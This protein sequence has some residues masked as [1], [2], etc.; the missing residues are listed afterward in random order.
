MKLTHQVHAKTLKA[1]CENCHLL[2]K[3]CICNLITPVAT[4]N[5]V[6]LVITKGEFAKMTN[7]GRL[8]HLLLQNS[9]IKVFGLPEKPLIKED[10]LQNGYRNLLLYP[11]SQNR[12]ENFLQIEEPINLIVP[13]GNWGQA[14]KMVQKIAQL[15][16]VT[17]VSLPL[18][19]ISEYMLRT[20]PDPHRIC[21]IEAIYRS[22][23]ILENNP[24][25]VQLLKVFRIMRDRLVAMRAKPLSLR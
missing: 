13:D 9:Q 19:P 1:I 15:T 18:G 16:P 24:E 3:I 25:L 4:R 8:A 14:K 7:T 2:Q 5:R 12:F 22:L 6:S 11:G 23:C 10:F 20:H 21:T 17:C